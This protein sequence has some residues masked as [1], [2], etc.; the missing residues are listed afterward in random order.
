[1][2]QKTEGVSVSCV[3]TK[4]SDGIGNTQASSYFPPRKGKVSGCCHSKSRGRRYREVG[5]FNINS[6]HNRLRGADRAPIQRRLF[7]GKRRRPVRWNDGLLDMYRLRFKSYLK[8]PGYKMQTD[9]RKDMNMTFEAGIGK[10]AFIQYDGEARVAFSPSGEPFN[11]YVRK[12]L[13][14]PVLLGPYFKEKLVDERP[15]TFELCGENDLELQRTR[16]R[17]LRHLRGDLD[18]ELNATA[19]DIAQA[20]LPLYQ[21]PHDHSLGTFHADPKQ[22]R[23]ASHNPLR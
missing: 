18:T 16:T 9:K 21:A 7:F 2:N 15:V 20:K 10:G 12:V 17:L 4:G 5:F 1:M 14:I 23:E 8:N 19:A 13:N 3:Y 11:I 6:Q 22:S